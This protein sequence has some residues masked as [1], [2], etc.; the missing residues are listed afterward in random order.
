MHNGYKGKHW[1]FPLNV[2]LVWSQALSTDLLASELAAKLSSLCL[3]PWE[4]RQQKGRS[5]PSAQE[6]WWNTWQKLL[7]LRVVWWEF[8][9]HFAVE[10]KRTFFKGFSPRKHEKI[11][12]HTA[13]IWLCT[14]SLCIVK[15]QILKN[16]SNISFDYK[17]ADWSW[18]LLQ[19]NKTLKVK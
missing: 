1:P 18:F 13:L 17:N 16:A 7:I 12:P 14:F 9:W 2:G 5:S 4:S 3:N 8:L 11:K 6:G 10:Q 15:M 19:M